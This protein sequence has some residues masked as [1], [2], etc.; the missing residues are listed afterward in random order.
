M[1]PRQV[2]RAVKGASVALGAGCLFG[3]GTCVQ[4]SLSPLNSE[5]EISS[6]LTGVGIPLEVTSSSLPTPGISFGFSDL[7]GQLPV[8]TR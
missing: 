1:I 4:S 3:T 2:L 5:L 7:S 6:G 8:I